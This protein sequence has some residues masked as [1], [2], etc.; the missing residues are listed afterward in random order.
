MVSIYYY[1][2]VLGLR[3]QV[4]EY[5]DIILDIGVIPDTNF[6]IDNWMYNMRTIGIQLVDSKITANPVMEKIP[7]IIYEYSEAL[8]DGE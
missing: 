7:T 4:D 2:V 3:Y 1:D 6:D 8:L 5:C